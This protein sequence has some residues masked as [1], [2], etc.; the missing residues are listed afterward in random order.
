MLKI[1]QS[2][3][4]SQQLKLTQN[5]KQA[6]KFLEMDVFEL[7]E[8]LENEA[9]SNVFLDV[10]LPY[11]DNIDSSQDAQ[12]EY[13]Y[14]TGVYDN[15]H[16]YKTGNGEVKN[17]VEEYNNLYS[18]ETLYEH[19][20]MQLNFLNLDKKTYIAARV[21]I[22]YIDNKG[23]LSEELS[24]ISED[25]GVSQKQLEDAL[26]IVQSFNPTGVAARNLKELIVIQLKTMNLY[27]EEHLKVLESGLENIAYGKLNKIAS[28]TNISLSDINN[29]INDI[30]LCNPYIVSEFNN[31]NIN[32]SYVYPEII[33][34]IQN[35]DLLIYLKDEYYPKVS[36]SNE[37][38]KKLNA[39]DKKSDEY[40]YLKEN[41]ERANMYIKAIELRK[42]NIL[43]ITREI[44]SVQRDFFFNSSL[45]P[46]TMEE[47]ANKLNI[48]ISTVSRI[49]N[50]K[51]ADT[52]KGIFPLR[53]FFKN[54]LKTQ[55]D[56]DNQSD[57]DIK[58]KITDYIKNE[59]KTSP[60]SDDAISKKLKEEGIKISRRTVAK[61]RES[62]SIPSSYLRKK[63]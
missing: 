18:T 10:D 45:K 44:F 53:F 46:L 63:E 60:L 35:D 61:Y 25:T 33:I 14:E 36:V 57:W 59:N 2:Y 17:E 23:Y 28:V 38:Q 58:N 41:Y 47:I 4:Q 34:K 12:K 40:S 22:D 42:E 16:S 49:A 8:F 51:Y 37:Y 13:I 9:L 7:G 30:K 50:G 29:I 3:S 48:S 55:G 20:L 1:T 62:L 6:I 19:L 52:P 56:T 32:L 39:L 15:F 26:E 54:A 5:L 27:T 43:N 11:K 24:K 31:D 21:I